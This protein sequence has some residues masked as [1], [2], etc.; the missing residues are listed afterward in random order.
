MSRSLLRCAN[1]DEHFLYWDC[2]E[3]GATDSYTD[4]LTPETQERLDMYTRGIP[5]TNHREATAGRGAAFA[6]RL[7]SRILGET[8]YE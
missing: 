4:L 8:R 5:L 2:F 6:D 3:D 7:R 1:R